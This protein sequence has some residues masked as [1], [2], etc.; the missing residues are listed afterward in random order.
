[1]QIRQ[2]CPDTSQR[3]ELY[4]SR[5]CPQ[6]AHNRVSSYLIAVIPRA[7]KSAKLRGFCHHGNGAQRVVAVFE[8]LQG[9]TFFS[10]GALRARDSVRR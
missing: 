1:M 5:F 4:R 10:D 6:F 2:R 9:H 3:G 8:S 7:S